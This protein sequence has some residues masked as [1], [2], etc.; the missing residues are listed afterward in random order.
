M[1]RAL[2]DTAMTW[3][4]SMGRC[5]YAAV[6]T[7]TLVL[8]GEGRVKEYVGGY[9]EWL[10]QRDAAAALTQAQTQAVPVSKPRPAAA[11][12]AWR[13]W[14][15]APQSAGMTVCCIART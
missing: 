2:R 4:D 7:S 8:E 13:A 14:V 11:G 15:G 1:L 3:L 6:V 5:L 9:T 12:R 10:R